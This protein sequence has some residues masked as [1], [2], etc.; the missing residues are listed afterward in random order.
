MATGH[1]LGELLQ[2]RSSSHNADAAHQS[3]LVH[4]AQSIEEGYGRE[5]GALRGYAPLLAAFGAAVGA[6][7]LA[8]WKSGRRPSTLTPF[9]FA[10][11]ALA[12]H[13]VSRLVATDAVTSPLRAPFTEF[14]GSAGDAELEEE[15]TGT[16]LRKAVGELITC[17]FCIAPW[18]AATFLTG[19]TLAPTLTRATTSALSAVAISDFLQVGYAAAQQRVTPASDRD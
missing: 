11:L 6:V 4:V 8:I 15:V 2:A 9:E 14:H 16:G 5:D 3:V 1:R 17:P 12:T 19:H 18:A 13:K 10:C 7:S